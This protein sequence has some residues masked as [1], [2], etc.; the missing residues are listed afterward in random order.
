MYQHITEQVIQ[1]CEGARNISDDIIVFGKTKREHDARVCQVLE[2]LRDRGLTLNPDKSKFCM[3][4]LVF[5]SNVLS[6]KGI[7]PEEVKVEAILHAKEPENVSE[8]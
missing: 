3:D 2:R 6:R 4:R 1:G 8:V 5:M 7:A